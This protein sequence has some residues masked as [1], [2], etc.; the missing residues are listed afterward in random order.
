[1]VGQRD[2]AMT[3]MRS[4]QEQCDGLRGEIAAQEEKISSLKK[5]VRDLFMS[6]VLLKFGETREFMPNS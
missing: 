1:M 2:Q 4:Y 3:A 5:L 6:C